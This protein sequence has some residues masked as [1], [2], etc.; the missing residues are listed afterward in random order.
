MYFNQSKTVTRYHL[1][2]LLKFA[3]CY[4]LEAF[5]KLKSKA[6][7]Y[8]KN[9]RID[10]YSQVKQIQDERNI[11]DIRDRAADKMIREMEMN[12]NDQLKAEVLKKFP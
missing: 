7:V 8:T 9:E 5:N 4:Y 1:Y 10:K 2:P 12:K 3:S 6:Y 11:R